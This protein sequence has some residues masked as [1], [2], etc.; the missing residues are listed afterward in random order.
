MMSAQA[1]KGALL[2]RSRIVVNVEGPA[3]RAGRG[4]ATAGQRR[5]RGRG[6]RILLIIA[7]VILA[8][9]LCLLAGL[10]FYWRSYQTSPDYSLALVVDA[11]QRGDMQTFDQLV[12]TDRIVDNFVPQVMEKAGRQNAPGP[13]GPMRRQLQS[14]VLKFA[15]QVK[16][17]VREEVTAQVKELSERA[18]HKPFFLVALAMPFTVKTVQEGDAARVNA[19]LRERPIELSMQRNGERWK[20]VGVRDDVLASRILENVMRDLPASAAGA[21]APQIPEELRRQ[22]EKRLPGGKLP[23]IPGL[24]K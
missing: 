15:P 8:L 9:V 5:G 6:G 3:E 21:G 18:E 23:D 7:L 13:D 12:D 10:Y 24:T 17:R 20:I 2:R 11:A 22:L 4:A 1:K 16:Q 19:N 14:L